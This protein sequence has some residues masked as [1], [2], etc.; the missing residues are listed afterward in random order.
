MDLREASK[1]FTINFNITIFNIPSKSG[2]AIRLKSNVAQPQ[3]A[4]WIHK[5]VRKFAEVARSRKFHAYHWPMPFN[6][7]LT[8]MRRT[9]ERGTKARLSFSGG[10]HAPVNMAESMEDWVNVGGKSRLLCCTALYFLRQ[11]FVNPW[12]SLGLPSPLWT[13]NQSNYRHSPYCP[14]CL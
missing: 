3:L 12:S 10:P 1:L 8:I 6:A 2:Y 7:I 14:P 13:Q 4:K 5:S 9:Y 11:V